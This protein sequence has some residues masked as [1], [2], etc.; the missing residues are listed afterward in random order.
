MKKQK[1]ITGILP[2]LCY[3]VLKKNKNWGVEATK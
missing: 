2:K 3:E 1:K